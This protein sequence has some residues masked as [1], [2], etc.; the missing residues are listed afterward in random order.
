M[1][2]CYIDYIELHHVPS[3]HLHHR[4]Y[5]RTVTSR[6]LHHRAKEGDVLHWPVT[7]RVLLR[8]HGAEMHARRAA[9]E[10]AREHRANERREEDGDETVREPT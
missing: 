1:A 9:R 8:V 5:L 3:R 4:A 10:R 6:Y 7:V 2:S